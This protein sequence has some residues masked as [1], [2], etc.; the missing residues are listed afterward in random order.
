ML[1][2]FHNIFHCFRYNYIQNLF[3][4]RPPSTL[5]PEITKCTY[6]QCS[7]FENICGTQ[8]FTGPKVGNNLSF[9][10]LWFDQLNVPIATVCYIIIVDN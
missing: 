3:F 2:I 5:S 10:C 8:C 7:N 9:L 6:V 1:F 4:F